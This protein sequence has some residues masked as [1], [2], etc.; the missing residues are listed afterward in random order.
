M[1]SGEDQAVC[2]DVVKRLIYI[3]VMCCGTGCGVGIPSV[4]RGVSGQV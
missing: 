3:I 1:H 4:D 2:V